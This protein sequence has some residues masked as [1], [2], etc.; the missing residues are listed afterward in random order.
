MPTIKFITEIKAEAIV[1]L[2]KVLQIYIAETGEKIIKLEISKVPIKRIPTTMVK[3]VRTA[4][5]VFKASAFTPVAFEKDS[6][7]VT[8]KIRL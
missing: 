3:A 4:I 6:S 1:T 2:L 8:A 7:K 5:T